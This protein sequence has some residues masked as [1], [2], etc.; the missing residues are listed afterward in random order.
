LEQVGLDLTVI[1]GVLALDTRAYDIPSLAQLD[2]QLPRAYAPV[3]G[4]DPQEWKAASPLYHLEAD[5][6]I[7][8]FV[9]A[10]SKGVFGGGL[11]REQREA[12]AKAFAAAL[13]SIGV[14]VLLVDGSE[15]THGEINQQFGRPGDPVTLQAMEF[16]SALMT[17]DT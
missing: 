1:K 8:P 15:K 9:I 4:E 12:F 3:F 2:G 7:P 17:S 5:K 14:E 6:H 16:L 13:E 10:W 11:D